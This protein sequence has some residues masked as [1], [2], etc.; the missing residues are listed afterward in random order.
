MLAIPKP[1]TPIIIDMGS[2]YVKIGFAGEPGP[3]FIFPCITG[4]EKYKAVMADVS[5]RSIYVGDDAMKM[6]GVLKVKR[7]I[8]RTTIM[9]WE[10]FYEILNHIFYTL[11]RIENLSAYPVFYVEPSFIQRE[12]KE[13]IARVLFE[14]HRV[15][16]LIMVPSPILSIFAVGLTTGLVVESGHGVT[17]IVPIVNG[18]VYHQAI[19][20]LNLAGMDVIG[21]LR[22]L[23]MREGIN[24]QSSAVEEIMREIVE[25]NCYFILNPNNPPQAMENFNYPMPDGTYLNIPQHILYLAPEVLFQPALINANTQSIPQ[26]TISSLYSIN[27]AYWSELLSHVVL[28]GGN[29]SYPGFEERFK[30]ELTALLPQLGP[31][32]KP[33]ASSKS[34]EAP[35]LQPMQLQ[36]VRSETKDQDTCS[37]CGTLVNLTDGKEFCPSCGAPM[38]VPEIS[39]DLNL[40]QKKPKK[41][42]EGKCPHCKKE[43]KDKTSLFCPYCGK[44]LLMPQMPEIAG[45]IPEQEHAPEFSGFFES[46]DTES[47]LKFFI[48]DN[49]QYAT[50]YGA[51]ILGSLPSF[52][53]LFI[54]PEKFQTNPE[55]LYTDISSIF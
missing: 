26:A 38:K 18:K 31:I 21:N 30:S 23:L 22:T 46:S 27:S 55:L 12:T 15:Q 53:S 44:K 24:I 50:F 33:V 34:K 42:D 14:T 13:Y 6:R 3:R 51:S 40:N 8:E 28:S 39:L 7:P 52:L 20:K 2:A 1:G 9:S 5:T 37:K 19:Q 54:T 17:T 36:S 32:P 10:D 11:L 25:K 48:P 16:S 4:T 29:L 35:S 49:L 47:M 43:I 45:Q 41:T